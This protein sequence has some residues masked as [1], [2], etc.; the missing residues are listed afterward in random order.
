MVCAG[1][2]EGAGSRPDAWVYGDDFVILIESKVVGGLNHSQIR[3]HLNTLSVGSTIKPTTV[4]KTWPDIYRFFSTIDGPL[5]SKDE[6]LVQQFLK[7]LEWSNM[8]DFIGFD[9]ECFEFFYGPKDKDTRKWLRNTFTLFSSALLEKLRELDS[10]YEGFDIGNIK[11]NDDHCWTAFG[12]TNKEYRKFAH[13]SVSITPFGLEVFFNV[14]TSSAVR[15]LRKLINNFPQQFQDAIL[16][17][18]SLKTVSIIV[19]ERRQRQ[20][21]LYDYALA[22]QIEHNVLCS[23]NLGKKSFEYL[24]YLLNTIPFP[25]FKLQIFFGQD[26]V[27][28]KKTDIVEEVFSVM[29]K[30][31][32]L[33][34]SVNIGR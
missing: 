25:Q 26:Q 22:A 21:S 29:R 24:T 12:P 27:V 14:E 8:S 23:Q 32:P 33:V 1:S 5:T 11:E 34:T 18:E 2:R 13:Q 31:H 9:Y 7:Y 4:I 17:L 6:W 16:N 3:R 28:S 10:F 15:R 20:A 30:F 19:I